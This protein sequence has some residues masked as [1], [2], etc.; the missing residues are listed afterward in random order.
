MPGLRLAAVKR[1]LPHHYRQLTLRAVHDDTDRFRVTGRAGQI[2]VEGTS[3]AVLLTGLSETMQEILSRL[4]FDVPGAKQV[5]YGVCLLLVVMVLPDGHA[6]IID[7]GLAARVDDVSR[8]AAGTF[9]YVAPEQTGML[10]RLVDGRA[11]LYALGVLLYQLLSGQLPFQAAEA[12]ALLQ[13]H[14]TAPPP[15]LP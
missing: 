8:A 3:P 6:K 4:G 5:F 7:F 2:T 13:L 15:S 11:D 9:A 12:L 10:N 1:L 14:A